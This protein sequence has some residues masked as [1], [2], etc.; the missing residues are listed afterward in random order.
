VRTLADVGPAKLLPAEQELVRET[1]DALFFC[2]SASD[3]AAIEALRETRATVE[4]LVESGR[5]TEERAAELAA[6]LEA[7]GPGSLVA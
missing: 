3:V 1:A 5:W 6:D 7:C 2:E 4:R